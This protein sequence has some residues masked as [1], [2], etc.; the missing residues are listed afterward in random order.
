MLADLIEQ[1][2]LPQATAGDWVGCAAILNDPTI[3]QPNDHAWTFGELMDTQGTAN[4]QLVAATIEQA[5]QTN[6]LMNSAFIALSTTGLR[7]DSPDRQS[8]VDQLGVLGAWPQSLTDAIKE[9]GIVYVA[10]SPSVVTAQE[11]DDAWTTHN[12]PTTGVK[13]EA[14]ISLNRNLKNTNT[15]MVTTAVNMV[16]DQVKSRDPAVN[17]INGQ[18]MTAAAQT[19]IDAINAA[20]NTYIGTL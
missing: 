2:A 1:Y 10:P 4:M 12:S 20:M 8:L 7:L 15:V 19:C 5:G 17:F 18:P 16:G 6:A 13:H 9:S 3:A 11:C 14:R